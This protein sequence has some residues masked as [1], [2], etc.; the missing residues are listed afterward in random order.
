MTSSTQRKTAIA[1]RALLRAC[2]RSGYR[3]E[4]GSQGL[5]LT[6]EQKD[7]FAC[8]LC[9]GRNGPMVPIANDPAM[10]FVRRDEDRCR[11][12]PR[13]YPA[14][15]EATPRMPYEKPADD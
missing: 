9:G 10:L 8:A 14:A 2:G 5:D 11:K 12:K 6:P 15:V 3:S 13:P 7:G 1:A 4:P